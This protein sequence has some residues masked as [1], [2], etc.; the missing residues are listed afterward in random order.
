MRVGL[1]EELLH[2][3]TTLPAIFLLAFWVIAFYA[4]NRWIAYAVALAMIVHAGDEMLEAAVIDPI[5]EGIH[6]GCIGSPE[7]VSAF[8][9]LMGIALIVRVHWKT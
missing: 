4:R 7:M 3:L 9:V 5:I 2:F 6:V 1:F 8:L